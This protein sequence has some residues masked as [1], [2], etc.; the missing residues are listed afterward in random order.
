MSPIVYCNRLIKSM[1]SILELTLKSGQRTPNLIKKN[2]VSHLNIIILLG[3]LRYCTCM[4]VQQLFECELNNM[5]MCFKY[6]SLHICVISLG[7][8]KLNI[9][10]LT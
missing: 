2:R 5:A 3:F 4:Y 1:E 7:N 10:C 8:S 6:P 9:D